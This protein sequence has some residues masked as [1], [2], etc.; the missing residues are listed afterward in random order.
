MD[1]ATIHRRVGE[2]PVSTARRPITV[3]R[4]IPF[5]LT[6]VLGLLVVGVATGTLWSALGGRPLFDVVAYGLPALEDGRWWTPVTGA[7][8]ALNPLEYVPVVGGFLLLA[9]FAELRLGTRRTAM[10]TVVLQLGAVL[11]ASSF[12]AL[13]RG[14]GWPW[15]DE[16]SRQLD[17]GF[18]AGA[19]GVA[20][21]ASV[22]LAS[23]WRGR[24]RAVLLSYG[25]VS[26][27]YVGAIWDVEHVIAI[28]AGLL[29]G[30]FLVGRRPTLKA[31]SLSRHELR[32]LAAGGFVV[33]AAASLL[34]GMGHG[35]PLATGAKD[36]VTFPTTGVIGA[37]VWLLVANGVR[38]GRRR[39]WRWALAFTGLI[40]LVIVAYGAELIAFH[41]PGWPLAV[42]SF[43]IVGTQ[44]T[45]LVAGRRAFR[46][47]SRRR[48]RRTAGSLLSAPGEDQ[49]AA[50]REMLR[51]EGTVNRLAWMTTWPENRWFTEDGHGGGYVAYRPHA[52]VAIGLCDPVAASPGQRTALLTAYAD[53]VRAAGL[54]PCLFSV[55]QEAA[56]HATSL[57]WNALQ[58]AE[59]AVI[60]LPALEFKGKAWQDVRTA[61]NQAD[62]LGIIHR[63]GPLCEQPR[64]IQVQVRAISEAWMGD[65]GLP[66]MGFTLGGVDEAMDPDVRVGL[67]VD[68][69][70]TVHGVTSWMPV[71][72]PGGGAPVGWTLDVMRRAPDGFRYTM[73]FLIASACLAFKDEGAVLVSLS[74][75][76]LAKAGAH[77]STVERTGLDSFLDTLGATLEPYYGFR[78]LQAFKSKFQPRYEPLYLVFP[79]EA[80]LPRIGIALSRAYLP[81]AGV[82]DLISLARQ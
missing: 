82:R 7:F 42:Y 39:A 15:A 51:A 5:T 16:L 45:I 19:L 67:A 71:H 37:L 75:V 78:S 8:F 2:T 1:T 52:G 72:A 48:A 31:P 49:R 74:G 76:P 54:L 68:G 73:E 58:V 59:E 46:N 35:G 9:G 25:L 18:S 64:G 26:L 44:L 33:A 47:P 23:P 40:M 43:L 11:A 38:K 22:T 14:H 29:W 32:F 69:D 56:D 10:V 24:L 55:T 57:G 36:T 13:T 61:L 20:A 3:L 50:A 21:A 34:A 4:R 63:L 60:D 79:D 12:L 41:E 53:K 30:P 28:F 17:A 6:V 65:K 81:E 80:A 70:G 77:D 66:E 62:K 27:M